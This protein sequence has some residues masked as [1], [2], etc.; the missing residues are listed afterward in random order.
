MKKKPLVKIV[1]L[2]MFCF[3]LSSCGIIDEI[4]PT[5]N[6]TSNEES[7]EKNN[8]KSNEESDS[9]NK[10]ETNKESNQESFKESEKESI[11]ESEKESI[12]ESEKESVKESEKESIKE[13]EKESIK[14]S[15]KESDKENKK[16]KDKDDDNHKHGKSGKNHNGKFKH[17][18]YE[19]T[20]IREKMKNGKFD[21]KKIA[22][23][24]FDD[25]PNNE[26]T[27]RILDILRENNVPATFFTIGKAI[28]EGTSSIV[29]RMFNEGH[30]IAT[31]SFSHE[32]EK[33]YPG[34]YP[35]A[36][37][38]LKEEKNTIQ[39]L[40]S[41]LGENFDSRVFR[42]PGGHMSWNKEGL[43][44][45]DE[46]LN[47]N[48]IHWIDWN[49][50]T[51]DAQPKKAKQIPRPQN[52]Q[53]VINN[54]DESGRLN[55]AYELAVVLMHDAVGK[56]ITVESLPKLISHLKDLGFEFGILE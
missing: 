56:E 42:Y 7:P 47:Q 53:Q 46:L 21:G 25:G 27:P 34:R 19:V 30:A 1:L 13:S 52:V 12:K 11:K 24:T 22:F 48:N 40:K 50:M 2:F 29:K 16:D 35:D 3:I 45:S 38:I 49:S 20:S 39:R 10:I 54:F 18:A 26:V 41:I 9:E 28:H 37:R 6:E 32:Y 55:G 17:N 43:K 4:I 36:H 15:E 5:T 51:G 44:H 33:L 14:E 8:E 23:L 31:H